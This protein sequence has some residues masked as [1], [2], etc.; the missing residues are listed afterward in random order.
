MS[1]SRTQSI[2]FPY[3]FGEEA[4]QVDL[5]K[6]DLD[7]R[8]ATPVWD[9]DAMECDLSSMGSWTKGSLL[10]QVTREPE[11]FWMSELVPPSE[12]G[13]PPVRLLAAAHCAATFRRL[14]FDGTLDVKEGTGR[15]EVQLTREELAE[16]VSL[17]VFVVRSKEQSVDSA[18]AGETAARLVASRRLVIRIEPAARQRGPGLN[19]IW[20][21][22]AASTHPYRAAHSATLFHVDTSGREPVLYLNSDSDPDLYAILKEEAPRGKRAILRNVLFSAIAFPVWTCLLRNAAMAIDEE[23]NVASGWQR[24]VIMEL[25][26]VDWPDCDEQEALRRFIRDM[27]D[28]TGGHAFEERLPVILAELISFRKSAEE[29]SGVLL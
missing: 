25:A 10:F 7:G 19:V 2:F 11:S 20:E 29:L 9:A 21:G 26:R 16:T 27:R 28:E 14:R 22:F 4:L 6:C 15:V 24:N 1:R 17:D 18:L 8:P 13:D 5:L 12:R 3:V 23:G